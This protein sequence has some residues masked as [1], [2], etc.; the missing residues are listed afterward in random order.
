MSVAWST[1]LIAVSWDAPYPY[2]ADGTRSLSA[3]PE[4]S[5]TSAGRKI[6]HLTGLSGVRRGADPRSVSD[7]VEEEGSARRG[8]VGRDPKDALRRAA[9]D[10]RDRPLL[11]GEARR[12][13]WLE[14][15]L[16]KL[17]RV[18]LIVVDEVGYIP[19][20]PDAAPT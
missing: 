19:F 7:R 18:P 20:D 14:E 5:P 10:P 12:R 9:L 3:P 1:P 11:L 8:E 16:K 4:K 2:A 15:E 17:E 6:P 13:G